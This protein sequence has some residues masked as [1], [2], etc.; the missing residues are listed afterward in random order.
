M[1]SVRIN[2][3]QKTIEQS[4]VAELIEALGYAPD[5]V[6]VECNMVILGRNL[7][8]G[9]TLRDGDILEIIGFVGGG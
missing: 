1:I 9:T 3:E 5:K 2:G 4:N 8:S 7:W 6:A